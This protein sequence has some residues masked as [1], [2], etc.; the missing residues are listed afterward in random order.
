MEKNLNQFGDFLERIN[1]PR[2]PSASVDQDPSSPATIPLADALRVL[3]AI[4]L[5]EPRPVSQLVAGLQMKLT[6]LAFVLRQLEAQSL[7]VTRGAG[8][9]E[10]VAL[11]PSGKDLL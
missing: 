5:E 10:M 7:V 2:R 9:A 6:D 8:N 4:G 1:E 3:K 11:T